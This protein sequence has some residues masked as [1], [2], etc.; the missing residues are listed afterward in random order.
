MS[1]RLP[2]E[3]NPYRLVEQ[4]RILDGRVALH[5]LPRLKELA[6]H[7]KNEVS[8]E[9]AFEVTDTGLPVINGK[10]TGNVPLQCQRCMEPFDYQIDSVL[11]VILIKSDAEAELLQDSYDTWMVEDDRIFLLDFIEDELLLELPVVAKHKEC[12]LDDIVNKISF[13]EEDKEALQQQEK[14]GDNP[15]S[16]LKNWKNTE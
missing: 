8:V 6:A 13:D 15:F 16:E 5:D 10:I 12:E 9:L 3:I 14:A 11:A 2:I 7:D 1:S 4:R